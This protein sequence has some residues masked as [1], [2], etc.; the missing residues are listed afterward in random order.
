MPKHTKQMLEALKRPESYDSPIRNIRLLQTHISWVFLT[1]DYAY[2]IKK[3]VDFGFLDFTTLDK[4]KRFCLKE[5]EINRMFSEDIYIDVL[6]VNIFS[7]S[8]KVNGPGET[9]DYAIKMKELPQELLMDKLLEKN[10][11][12]T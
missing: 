11:I 7:D 9:I 5:L 2:K 8:I 3:P 12:E 6:P 1:G 10:A 4:R